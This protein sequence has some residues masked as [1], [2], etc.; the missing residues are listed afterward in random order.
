[1]TC[2]RILIPL[3]AAFAAALVIPTGAFAIGGNYVISGGTDYQQQQ[4]RQALAV[5]TFD[6]SVVPAKV[7]IT[8]GGSQSSESVPGQIW[9]SSKLLNSGQFSWGVVQHEYAHQ[10]DF[11]LFDDAT[12]A[13][14]E[15]L[16]GANDWCYEVSGLQHA[17]HGCERF[18][19]TLAWAY[20]PSS[21]NCMRPAGSNSESAAMAPAAFRAVVARLLGQPQ[22]DL[23]VR[24]GR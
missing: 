21:Q 13:S 2:H 20:W 9:I 4:V 17:Q 18:A 23:L 7:T 11:F 15:L 3:L 22:P 24:T 12:R 19:S 6:W 1:M 8:I 16:L 14:L 10:V 5:S